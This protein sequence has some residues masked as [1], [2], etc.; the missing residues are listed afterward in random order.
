MTTINYNYEKFSLEK[1]ESWS[2]KELSQFLILD[3]FSASRKLGYKA[4]KKAILD[5]LQRSIQRYNQY[6]F[7]L[8]FLDKFISKFFKNKIE[9]RKKILF[10]PFKYYNI[11]L[12]EKKYYQ[13][14]LIVHGN[15]D[16][17]FAIKNF[18][19][20]MATDDLDQYILAYLKEKDIK[21]LHR[22]IKEIESKLKASRPDYI[23]LWND[24]T[25][26]ERAI[27]LVSKKLGITTLE[28]QHGAYDLFNLETGKVVDYVL[29]WGEYSKNLCVQQYKRK[30]EDIYVLGYPY[31]IK[32]NEEIKK[33]VVESSAH[34][35]AGK[36]NHYMV[37]YLGQNFEIYNKKFLNIKVETIKKINEICNKLGIDFIYR[38][39]PGD[40]RESLRK[41]LS[42]IQFTN[43]KE[44]L[45]ETF[46]KADI[47]IS[48]N[49]TALVEAAMSSKIS[50]Q[51][52]NYPIK[53]DNLERLGACSKSFETIEEL[54]D[55]LK[56]IAR[57]KNL[58][59]FKTKFNN[60]YVETRYNPIE[61]FSEIIKDIEKR[62]YEPPHHNKL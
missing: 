30:P 57:A 41:N 10:R 2:E 37:C 4:P 43:I 49:S 58:K 51:L 18:M 20:Y 9:K 29:A 38:P 39:H 50:L 60:D 48:F 8:F 32:G 45:E 54:E 24:I 13:V 25:P 14:A 3:Y 35:R 23:V 44:G 33:P 5:A 55:Y 16:R 28:I 7:I 12:G 40:N 27:V 31:M 56:K 47:F 52:L 26:M 22:L 21:Y 11:I 62:K 1:M 34:Y 6:K 17:L 36:N 46:K 53:S 42:D 19:D 61:R 15:W 59:E